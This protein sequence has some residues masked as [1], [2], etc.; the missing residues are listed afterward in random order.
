[1]LLIH[2]LFQSA[3]SLLDV[4]SVGYPYLLADDCYNVWAGNCRGNYYGRAHTK[5]NPDTDK[6]FWEFST[7]E[8]G[9]YD[10]PA[11]IDYVLDQTGAETLNYVG[12]S[13]GGGVVFI[14]CS[15]KPEY[16]N[17]INLIVSISPATRITNT[18]SPLIRLLF[19]GVFKLE[20]FVTAA[21]IEE[22]FSRGQV[23]Q[24]L[25]ELLCNMKDELDASYPVC[26]GII[27]LIDPYHIEGAI[28]PETMKRLYAHFPA[29][30]SVRLVSRF[31]QGL[32]SEYFQK[33][34]YGCAEENLAHYNR[35]TPPIYDVSKV[36]VPVVITYGEND[37]LAVKEDVTWLKDQLPKVLDFVRVA[38]DS[39]IHLDNAYNRNL[40]TLVYPTVSKYL[41]Q[42][43]DN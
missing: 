11:H 40:S 43:T 19:K 41:A 14:T 16:N 2:G 18:K 5:Y 25:L 37:R 42:Y 17:K 27:N 7:D 24:T 1:M 6:E 36:T 20:D 26:D 32:S 4:G 15:E 29:G 30:T 10:I 13:Q 35:S 21:G 33:Y 38:D 12:Y 9:I 22:V 28:D 39:W 8:V 31:G 3:D 34:D 23:L